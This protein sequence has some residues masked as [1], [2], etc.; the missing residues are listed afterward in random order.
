MQFI[1]ILGFIILLGALAMGKNLGSVVR[2]GIIVLT[3]IL[4]IFLLFFY[5]KIKNSDL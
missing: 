1:F 3:I 4:L 5:Y 2:R